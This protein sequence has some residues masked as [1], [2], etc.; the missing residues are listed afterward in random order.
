MA[1]TNAY[2]QADQLTA[3]RRNGNQ[4]DLAEIETV[5]NAV[6]RAIDNHCHHRFYADTN[7]TAR[8]YSACF[9]D[10]VEVDDISTTDSLVIKTDE[11][12]NGTFEYT[13][14]ASDYQLEPLNAIVRGRPINRIRRRSM[15][16]YSFPVSGDARVQVTAKWGWPSVPDEVTMAC[17]LQCN[18]II[19]RRDSPLGIL[20]SPDFGLSDR[21]TAALDPDVR[22][23]LTDFM[24]IAYPL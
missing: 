7:A 6:S 10:L 15:G 4:N 18:R 9:T 5:I 12:G 13:W 16:N 1:L 21:I 11:D 23:M 14:S 3:W 2:I 17:L 20:Q 19:S 8:V 22:Q 24:L